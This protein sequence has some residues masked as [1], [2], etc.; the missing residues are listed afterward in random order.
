MDPLL[1]ISF[2][3]FTN[4]WYWILTGITWSVTCHKTLGVPFDSLVRAHQKGGA[5]ATEAED[6]ALLNISRIIH[7][8]RRSGVGIIGVTTFFLAVLATFGFYY[9][10]ELAQA[11]FALIAPL[12]VV[13]GMGVVLAFRIEREVIR[14]AELRSA[15]TRRRFW[16]QVIGL[17]SI[18]CAAILTFATL[19][20]LVTW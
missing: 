14:G 6:L 15:L 19:A 17:F 3:S 1:A 11:A 20:R 18:F 9:R 7:V 13:H 4:V 2:D 12:T 8:F 16:N 10:Y 5:F